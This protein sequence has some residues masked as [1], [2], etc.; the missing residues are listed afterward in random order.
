MGFGAGEGGIWEGGGEDSRFF[1]VHIDMV[2]VS[3]GLF[4]CGGGGG[5]GGGRVGF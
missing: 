5:G 1:F 3:V 4:G 2:L